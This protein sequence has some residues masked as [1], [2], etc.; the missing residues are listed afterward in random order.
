MPVFAWV[1]LADEGALKNISQQISSDVTGSK[2]H[3]AALHDP[4]Q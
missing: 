1:W 2:L 3:I 4:P